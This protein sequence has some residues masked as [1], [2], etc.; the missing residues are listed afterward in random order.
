MTSIC[1]HAH[2]YA[3]H[4][5]D[6]SYLIEL[7]AWL[8]AYVFIYISIPMTYNKH[9]SYKTYICGYII[10]SLLYPLPQSLRLL[11]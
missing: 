9:H 4:M 8:Y 6:S 7:G 11:V 2:I 1:I 5:S 3:I 10:M